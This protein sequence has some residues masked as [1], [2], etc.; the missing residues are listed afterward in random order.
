MFMGFGGGLDRSFSKFPFG[1]GVHD[2]LSIRSEKL[3]YLTYWSYPRSKTQ[4]LM[5]SAGA[6][7]SDGARRRQAKTPPPHARSPQLI[8]ESNSLFGLLVKKIFFV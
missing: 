7:N 3:V 1:L 5:K 2:V 8:F 6:S 4:D